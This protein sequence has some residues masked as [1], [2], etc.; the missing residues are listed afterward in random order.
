M[1]AMQGSFVQVKISKKKRKECNSDLPPLRHL[2]AS[3]D[4]KL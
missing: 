1:M 2:S 3:K 4:V